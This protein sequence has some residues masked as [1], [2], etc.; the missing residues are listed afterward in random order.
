MTRFAGLDVSQKMT[1]VCVVDDVGRRLWRG[2]ALP[3]QNGSVLWCVGM[4]EMTPA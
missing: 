2:Q 1:A 3:F 4:Q